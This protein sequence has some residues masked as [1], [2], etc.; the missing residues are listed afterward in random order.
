MNEEEMQVKGFDLLDSNDI[1][2]PIKVLPIPYRN[3][4]IV[5]GQVM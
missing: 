2:S 1:L 5:S 3:P 4:Q